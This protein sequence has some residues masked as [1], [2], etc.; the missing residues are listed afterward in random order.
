MPDLSHSRHIVQVLES[1]VVHAL[2]PLYRLTLRGAPAALE[3]AGVALHLAMPE[4]ACRATVDG[5]RAVLWLGPDERLLLMPRAL[6]APTAAALREALVG[7]AHALVDV[8]A[9]QI[10]L[11]VSGLHATTVLAAG[12]PLD[13]DRSA[14]PPGM[15]TRTVLAKAEIVLW[16]TGE[17]RFHLEVGR[18][19]TSYVSGFLAEVASELEISG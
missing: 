17:T 19:F 3:R 7:A 16:R 8:S 13:L 11:E 14:F 2:P 6:A 4:R 12:C 15:C 18:S 9:R 10:A 5:E 1:A